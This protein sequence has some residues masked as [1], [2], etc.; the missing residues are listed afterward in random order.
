MFYYGVINKFTVTK[1]VEI[2][3]ENINTLLM[4]N[5]IHTWNNNIPNKNIINVKYYKIINSF[6]IHKSTC[7]N[8]FS[9]S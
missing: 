1:N 2:K 5:E 6:V 3:H 9:K 8:V 4:S 7:R